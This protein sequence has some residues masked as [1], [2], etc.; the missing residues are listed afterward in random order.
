MDEK[1]NIEKI[2]LNSENLKEWVKQFNT[3]RYLYKEINNLD[4]EYYVGITGMRGI[5]K[6]VLLLQLASEKKDSVY[7]SAD[8]KLIKP[9]DMYD[10]VS[11]LNRRGFNNIFIDEIHTKPNWQED[12]K[13]LYDEHKL[14]VYFSG[15]SGIKIKKSG[16]DLSRRA[17]ILELKPA[18]F[19][20]YLIIKKG[21]QIKQLSV[22]NII[23]HKKDYTL[24]YSSLSEHW[25]EYMKYGGVLYGGHGF[26]QA[27]KNTIEKMILKDMAAL[28]EVSMK[29]ESDV[30]RFLYIAAN[31][32]PYE[33]SYSSIASKLSV[34][35]TFIIRM[36]YDLERIGLIKVVFPCKPKGRD[37]KKEPKIYLTVPYRY[38]FSESPSIGSLREEFFVNHLMP[39]CYYKTKRGEKTSDFRINKKVFEIGGV[40]KKHAQN[41]DYIINDGLRF[42]GSYIPLFLFGFVY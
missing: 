11:E 20:E 9:F 29:Y 40:S 21:H 16:A 26:S 22:D 28:R 34:S 36:I 38:Y 30:Y 35:K 27:L 41:P 24:K 3:K 39:D 8:S 7:F 32:L 25:N 6:T 12:I 33:I 1:I 15:S 4:N 17:L 5:G 10:V 2:I 23:R 14:K 18:S 19:R 31:S 13:T 37:I 42:D